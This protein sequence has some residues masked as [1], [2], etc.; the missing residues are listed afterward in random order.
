MVEI[1][2]KSEM[3]MDQE[4]TYDYM[5]LDNVTISDTDFD[6]D[7]DEDVDNNAETELLDI[8]VHKLY[9]E[10]IEREERKEY[11]LEIT[12]PPSNMKTYNYKGFEGTVWYVNREKKGLVVMF[13]VPKTLNEA[14]LDGI[15]EPYH[16]DQIVLLRDENG[17][18]GTAFLFGAY[19]FLRMIE[20]WASNVSINEHQLR[21]VFIDEKD[22]TRLLP[23]DACNA[24][25]HTYPRQRLYFRQ[26]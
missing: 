17:P 9:P 25:R 15:F 11:Q 7:D 14:D 2:P 18:A 21:A 26:N 20:S 24:L 10:E 8:S 13:N 23:A 5:D 19:Y 22:I 3:N 1:Y 12:Y 16:L 4:E 6:A